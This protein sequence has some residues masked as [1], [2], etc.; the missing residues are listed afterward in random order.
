MPEPNIPQNP[1]GNQRFR[2]K[3]VRNPVRAPSY[4]QSP[5]RPTTP[6]LPD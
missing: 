4:P 5:A 6:I 1:R 2:P 3:A